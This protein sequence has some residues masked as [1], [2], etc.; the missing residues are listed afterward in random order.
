MHFLP[1]VSIIFREW[2]SSFSFIPNNCGMERPTGR[3]FSMG[4]FFDGCMYRFVAFL[5]NISFM[6]T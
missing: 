4:L 1:G 3:E 6:K 2:V 5:L